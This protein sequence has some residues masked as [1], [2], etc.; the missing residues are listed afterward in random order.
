MVV[1]DDQDELT[2]LLKNDKRE[3][4]QNTFGFGLS[5]MMLY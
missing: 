2:Q 1:K 3:I 4:Y 5:T